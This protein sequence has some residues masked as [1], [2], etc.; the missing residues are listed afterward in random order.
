MEILEPR[1]LEQKTDDRQNTREYPHEVQGRDLALGEIQIHR[2]SKMAR[3]TFG[4]SWR[5]FLYLSQRWHP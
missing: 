3:G 1:P 5:C 2:E 4:H